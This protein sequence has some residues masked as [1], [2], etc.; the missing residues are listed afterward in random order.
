[1][2][3]KILKTEKG[4][5]CF[6]SRTASKIVSIP[7]SWKGED[8]EFFN[9]WLSKKDFKKL[10]A[11]RLKQ[12]RKKEPYVF[13][14]VSGKKIKG[15]RIVNL[16]DGIRFELIYEPNISVKVTEMIYELCEN[17]LPEIHSNY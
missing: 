3:I 13:E 1:M 17:K 6:S 8:H 10:L 2:E 14:L 12:I 16:R 11:S 7:S 5:V 15:S 4:L 9:N